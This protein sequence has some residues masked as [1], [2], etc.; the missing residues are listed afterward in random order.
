M[1]FNE[2]TRHFAEDY[3]G[4]IDGVV[5]AYPEDREEISY[6]RAILNGET[7]TAP[8]QLSCPWN[9]P[10]RAADFVSAGLPARVLSTNCARLRF[11]EAD[12]YTGRTAGYHFKQLL[13]DDSVVWEQDVAGGA[14]R[15]RGIGRRIPSTPRRTGF[16]RT[17]RAMAPHVL[18]SLA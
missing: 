10:T 2:I 17:H 14:V 5:V 16:A 8:G 7:L 1:Y 15:A 13:V 3:H 4:V 6:A 12:D 9:T 18:T 11:R